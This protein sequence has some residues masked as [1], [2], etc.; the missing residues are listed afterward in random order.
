[1]N[2]QDTIDMLEFAGVDITKGKAKALIE[3]WGASGQKRQQEEMNKEKKQYREKIKQDN[4]DA[5][6]AYDAWCAKGVRGSA[7]A[8]KAVDKGMP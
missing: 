1:M 5:L 7:A 3:G 8:K 6:K 4:P 2:K